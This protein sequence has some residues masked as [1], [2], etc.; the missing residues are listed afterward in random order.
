MIYER[1]SG[2]ASEQF[3]Q[4]KQLRNQKTFRY[5]DRVNLFYDFLKIAVSVCI[6]GTLA[7]LNEGVDFSTNQE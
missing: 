5:L 3:R 6:E 4:E 7:S 2:H 1:F